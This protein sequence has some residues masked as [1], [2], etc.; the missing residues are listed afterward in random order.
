[1]KIGVM[2]SIDDLETFRTKI[3]AFPEEGFSSCQ[4]L[5]WRPDLLTP[6]YAQTIREDLLR[7]RVTPSAFWAGWSGPAVW[8]FTEGPRTLGLVPP[9]YREVRVRELCHA[10]DFAAALGITDIV[11]HMG[12][13]PENPNDPQFLPFCRAVR[14]VATYL[15]A[16]GQ[17][18][19]FETGQ[20]TPI[21][22]LRC[23]DTVACDNLGVNLDTANLI[24]YGKAN[25]VDALGIFKGK[26]RNLHAKDGVY[27]TDPKRLGEETKLG[28]GAVNF[29]ALIRKLHEIGYDSHITIEREIDGEKQMRDIREAKAYLQR[30]VDEVYGAHC[31]Y[32]ADSDA[33]A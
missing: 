12:F 10:S 16:K 6:A 1:M 24:L 14:E 19:L 20:E 27:P 11:T 22:M 18:L 26:V 23:F 17:F 30:L 3:S 29:P 7:Y 2:L 4:L 9:E 15:Q 31:E 13:I 5:S 33:K 21:T 28:E 32:R 25:P 8:D